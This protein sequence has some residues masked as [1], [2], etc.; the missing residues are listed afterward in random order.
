[1]GPRDKDVEKMLKSIAGGKYKS[2]DELVDA[3]VPTK[4]RL[5]K[6]VDI[7]E[8]M[9]ESEALATIKAMADSNVVA[10]SYLGAGYYGTH[11]PSCIQRN[12]LENPGW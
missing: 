8:A 7:G 1:L 2:L 10:K 12:I 9:T 5:D 11:T 6:D 4:I 3:T